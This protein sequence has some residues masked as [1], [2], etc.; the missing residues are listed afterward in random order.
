[1]KILICGCCGGRAPGK[2]HWNHD[3][4]YGLCPA[5]VPV[6][7]NNPRA[8]IEEL[9]GYGK[10]GVNF[11]VPLCP[12]LAPGLLVAWKTLAGDGEFNGYRVGTLVEWDNG[13]AVIRTK[14]GKSAIRAD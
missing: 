12:G 6:I 11:A 4:G 9:K 14:E 5:C 10:P 7:L 1:M 3:T 2:Q 8:G 13:T